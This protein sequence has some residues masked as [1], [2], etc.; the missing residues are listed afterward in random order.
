MIHFQLNYGWG[1]DTHGY[2]FQWSVTGQAGQAFQ[3]ETSTNLSDWKLVGTFRND[4][5][6]GGYFDS[7]P[8]S[9]QR[10]YRI[11]PQ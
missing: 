10:F 6:I 5:A 3:L 2:D 7:N 11:V 4:G 1:L 9:A 8:S